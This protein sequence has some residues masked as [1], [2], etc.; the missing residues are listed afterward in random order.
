MNEGVPDMNRIIL[1]K[2]IKRFP[3]YKRDIEKLAG[4]DPEFMEILSDYQVTAEALSRW[5]TESKKYSRRCEECSELL[6]ELEIELLGYIRGRSR[7]FSNQ[8]G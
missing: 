5:S 3:E 2:L 7:S 1:R 6:K 4:S 8:I